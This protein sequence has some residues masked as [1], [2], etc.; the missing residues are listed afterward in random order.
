MRA[1]HAWRPAEDGHEA[2]VWRDILLAALAEPPADAAFVALVRRELEEFVTLATRATGPRRELPPAGS[3]E[4]LARKAGVQRDD[5]IFELRE[6]EDDHVAGWALCDQPRWLARIPVALGTPI[7]TLV[8]AV[9]TTLANAAPEPAARELLEAA[10]AGPS[11]FDRARIEAFG[12]TVDGAANPYDNAAYFVLDAMRAPDVISLEHAIQTT[13]EV[14]DLAELRERLTTLPM[15]ARL[16][17]PERF[18]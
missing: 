10:L 7:E 3:F 16:S 8:R 14:I 4:R 18:E 2:A 11:D 12:K 1:G 5:C 13:L 6:V 9:C 15:R 17:H